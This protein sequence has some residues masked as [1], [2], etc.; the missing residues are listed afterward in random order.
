MRWIGKS[1]ILIVASSFFL[2]FRI[3]SFASGAGELSGKVAFLKDGEVWICDLHGKEMKQITNDSGKV[4]DFL[5]SPNLKYL[6]YAKIVDYV[7]E[8]GLWEDSEKVPQRAVC[9]IVIMD[10]GTQ[11]IKRQRM[12]TEDTWIYISKWL[13]G[14]KLLYYSASGFDVSGFYAWDIRSGSKE[15]I[16]YNK[17]HVISNADYSADGSLTV[18]VDDAGLGKDYRENLHLVNSKTN[19]DRILVSKRSIANQRISNDKNQIAFVEVE[20][21]GKKYFDNLWVYDISRNSLDSL[22]QEAAGARVISWS[23]DDRHIGMFFSSEA[24]V[25]DVKDPSKIHRI[26]GTEFAWTEDGR[27]IFSQGNDIYLYDLGLGTSELLLKGAA[28]PAFL[29]KHD[30]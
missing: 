26:H 9:S 14:D 18:Y 19:E 23:F 15:E 4:D 1:G 22:R 7:D 27:I 20:S 2:L 13:P 5:F 29:W 12:P 11:E 17:G 16:E 8:P 24:L 6:A 25:V 28:K 3:S 10:L 30:D 21:V